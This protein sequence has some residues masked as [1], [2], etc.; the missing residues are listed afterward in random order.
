MQRTSL[1]SISALV[2]ALY[3]RVMSFVKGN[4][5]RVTRNDRSGTVEAVRMNGYQIEMDDNGE[6]EFWADGEVVPF[7][8]PVKH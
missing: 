8:A 6:V 1:A 5:V 7:D 4:R 3:I 2:G